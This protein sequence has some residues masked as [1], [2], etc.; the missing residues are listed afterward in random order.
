[1]ARNRSQFFTFSA[2]KFLIFLVVV[3]NRESKNLEKVNRHP[4]FPDQKKVNF[5]LEHRRMVRRAGS[6]SPQLPTKYFEVN[7]NSLFLKPE[8]YI[9]I[10]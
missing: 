1:M 8:S 2:R 7:V 3:Q 6:F 10:A 5:D 9:I 4:R